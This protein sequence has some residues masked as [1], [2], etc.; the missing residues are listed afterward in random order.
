MY[1]VMIARYK[2]FP[3]VKTK[4]MAAA[5]RLVLF[6]S[7]HVCWSL[8]PLYCTLSLSDCSACLCRATTPSRRPAQLWASG[9]RTWSCWT[10][11]KG[12]SAAPAAFMLP[13]DQ[14]LASLSAAFI[15]SRGR[16]IPADLEAKVIEAKQK[17]NVS[18]HETVR[19]LRCTWTNV[20]QRE[21]SESAPL[22]TLPLVLGVC[23]HVCERHRRHHRL[24]RLRPH[25]RDRRYLWEA[26][27]VASRGRKT[28]VSMRWCAAVDAVGLTV[29][30]GV[31]GAWGGGLLMSSKHRHKLNG[32]ER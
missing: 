1:S 3:V 2:F 4:G 5:P 20:E 31:Q 6:T 9:P 27:H 24:R 23:S 29:A 16:V 22:Y 12:L 30:C 10:R 13:T 19:L 32:V 7:E 17:V 18:I 15:F 21:V 11:M 28:L 8:P 25:Q 14:L 26:Q